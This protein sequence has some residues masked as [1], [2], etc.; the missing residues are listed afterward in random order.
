MRNMLGVSGYSNR[1]G[2]VLVLAGDKF[3]EK[4]LELEAFLGLQALELLELEEL[5]GQVLAEVALLIVAFLPWRK[6]PPEEELEP[7]VKQHFLF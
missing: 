3:L 1:L 2:V 4:E 5:S 7:E 6:E